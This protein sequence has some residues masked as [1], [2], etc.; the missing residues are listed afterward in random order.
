MYK[1][2]PHL[3]AMRKNNNYLSYYSFFT[4]YSLMDDYGFSSGFIS[5]VFKKVLPSIPEEGTFEFLLLKNQKDID[6]VISSMDFENIE[7]NYVCKELNL[8]IKALCLKIAAFG[9]DNEIIYR[10]KSLKLKSDS[11]EALI[12]EV[13]LLESNDYL[14][15]NT[16][17]SLLESIEDNIHSLR[18]HKG[19]IGVNLHLT[20]V[21]RRIL[22]YIDRAKELLD[23][24]V[25]LNSR[26]H[27]EKLLIKHID[28]TKTKY[29][30]RKF[31]VRHLDLLIFEVVEHTSNSGEKYIAETKQEYRNFLFKSMLGGA[32]IA[33]FAL[34]KIFIGS[35]KL[36]PMGYAFISSLNY[37]IC[38][39][40]VKQIGGIIATKQPAMTASTI[41]KNIDKNDD[42]KI[43][44]I[45]EIITVI[46][47]AMRSQFITIVG[48]F[49]MALLFA[50]FLF[51]MFQ[52]F[53]IQN[54]LG[55]EPEYLMKEI[56][57]SISLISYAATAGFFLALSGLISGFID[58]KVRASKI[59][60]RI[61][62][63]K[64]FLHSRTLANFAKNKGGVFIGNLSLGFFLGSA[65]LLSNLVPLSVDIRHIAFSSSYVGYAIVSQPFEMLTVLKALVG[66]AL[67][68]LTN[69]VV[70][71]SI[72]LLLALKS[73]G[74]KISLIPRLFIYSIKD[75]I[76]HPLDYFMIRDTS[77]FLKR[78]NHD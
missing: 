60:Y 37:A 45:Q 43:D 34:F 52:L 15:I 70:S 64:L 2:T 25:N 20:I 4:K 61:V 78:N 10:F 29:S 7:S 1:L 50:I 74:A 59:A 18:K 8:S 51:K 42:L 62:N 63:S 6:F 68:G 26:T 69:L 76:L 27:W 32:L 58:N 22:E 49:M 55:I 40:L 38:F 11:F 47:K 41:A 5:R 14:K 48:N 13:T 17:I 39:I 16:L 54:S 23:L 33:F 65:F 35:F 24:K 73:R 46:K 36:E 19:K 9:L 53:G 12:A 77:G 72:T 30:L 57:P 44:S 67:I 75:F 66:I 31:I 3:L 28:Y 71:F 56:M 21:T